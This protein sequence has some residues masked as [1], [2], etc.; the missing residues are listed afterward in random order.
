MFLGWGLFHRTRERNPRSRT[1][2]FLNVSDGGQLHSVNRRKDEH[3]PMQQV[4]ADLPLIP[5]DLT[6]IP[7]IVIKFN[8]ST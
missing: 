2:P 8:Y 3:L 4:H 7:I 1:K 6:V 5:N